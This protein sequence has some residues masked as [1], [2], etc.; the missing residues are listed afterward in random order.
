MAQRRDDQVRRKI[1]GAVV[2][3]LLI[4]LR[5]MARDLQEA[6]KQSSLAATR[7]TI[8][9]NIDNLYGLDPYN[10]RVARA[11]VPTDC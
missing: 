7:P 8:K 10:I 3:Q 4:A 2:K 1:I 9:G 5:T 6:P 11:G